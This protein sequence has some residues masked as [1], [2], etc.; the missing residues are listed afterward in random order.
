[1]V[2]YRSGDRN[3]GM[4]LDHCRLA[5]RELAHLHAL[6]IVMRRLRPEVF[7][8]RAFQ[9]TCHHFMHDRMD[10][11]KEEMR[12]LEDTVV[13]QV[14]EEVPE[15]L[16]LLDENALRKGIG[17]LSSRD[18]THRKEPFYTVVHNDFW[19]NNMMFA[20]DDTI[21]R[22]ERLKMVDFQITEIGSPVRD[23]LFFIYSSADSDAL[24]RVDDLMRE[25]H[26]ELERYVRLHGLDGDD[27]GWT[28]FQRELEAV[29][30]DAMGQLMLMT[31]IIRAQNKVE[32]TDND[33]DTFARLGV[34]APA[35]TRYLEIV[36]DFAKKGWV[37]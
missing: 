25:Y 15:V 33:D 29:A 14:L 27:L 1:A 8:G 13:K 36:R 19:V 20:Y 10:V 12:T 28:A 23:L 3:T 30:P 11:Y 21:G 22:P 6:G 24:A 31:S 7:S 17:T 26:A 5:L 4:D 34:S 16:T 35:K 18:T 9:E 2:G 32:K 37:R